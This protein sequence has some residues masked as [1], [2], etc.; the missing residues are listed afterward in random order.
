[1]MEA[2]WKR[3]ESKGPHSAP[4]AL[5]SEAVNKF[6]TSAESFMAHVHLLNEARVAYQEAISTSTELRNRLDAGDA[7]LKS[8]M[9]QLEQVV[10][11]HFSDVPEKKGPGLAKLEPFKGKTES[12]GTGATFP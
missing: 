11:D 7:A 9:A 12:P 5:Y 3:D 10:T 1:M 4:M 6:R 2:M 8:V